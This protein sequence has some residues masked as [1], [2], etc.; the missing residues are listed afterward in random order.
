MWL[1]LYKARQNTL[2]YTQPS[3]K[4]LHLLFVSLCNILFIPFDFYVNDIHTYNTR[5]RNLRKHTNYKFMK[6]LF[7]KPGEGNLKAQVDSIPIKSFIEIF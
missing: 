7:K 2:I 5:L 4:L 1:S 6:R 3:R